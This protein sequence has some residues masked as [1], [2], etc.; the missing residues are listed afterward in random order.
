VN[1]LD[2]LV[3]DR[4]TTLAFIRCDN[5]PALTANVLPDW[6]RLWSAGSAYIDSGSLWQNPYVERFGSRRRD[7]LL[8][9]ELF[10]CLP[11]VQ[12]VIEDWRQD[13]NQR[14]PRQRSGRARAR[15]A[16]ATVGTSTL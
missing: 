13:Y 3:A 16:P 10:S 12:T 14:R 6:C 7:E 4:A 5:A 11:E 2:R 1:V 8:S 9:V 15:S